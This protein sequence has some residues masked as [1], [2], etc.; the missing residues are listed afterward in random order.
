MAM[1]FSLGGT[2]DVSVGIRRIQQHGQ[3]EAS[4]VIAGRFRI[5][6]YRGIKHEFKSKR[7]VRLQGHVAGDGEFAG[8]WSVEIC[9]CYP[10]RLWYKPGRSEPFRKLSLH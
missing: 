2:G 9:C 8:F 10:T 3:R 5:G 4:W 6:S 7:L 1:T